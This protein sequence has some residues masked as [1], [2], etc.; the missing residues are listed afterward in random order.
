MYLRNVANSVC[1]KLY[2]GPNGGYAPSCN[3]ITQLYGWHS[4]NMSAFFFLNTS[5]KS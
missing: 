4:G 3:S 5:L 2:I 1:N